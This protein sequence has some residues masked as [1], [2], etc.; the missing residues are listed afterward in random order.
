MPGYE[1]DVLV[2]TD[3]GHLVAIAFG[4]A[5][6]ALNG[7][8]KDGRERVKERGRSSNAAIQLVHGLESESGKGGPGLRCVCVRASY[9]SEGSAVE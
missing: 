1:G 9:D 4:T 6:V 7:R 3:L 2:E 5:E 8:A